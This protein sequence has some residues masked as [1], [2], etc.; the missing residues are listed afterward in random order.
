MSFFSI[1]QNFEAFE[2]FFFQSD[3]EMMR[4]RKQYVGG[5][6]GERG[7]K[8]RECDYD[9]ILHRRDE[10]PEGTEAESVQIDLEKSNSSRLFWMWN[11]S[12]GAN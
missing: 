9:D 11:G 8:E 1:K 7:E 3:K 6:K 10:F 2:I 5:K 4:R 12:T